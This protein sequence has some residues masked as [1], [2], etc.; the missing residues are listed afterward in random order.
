MS[1]ERYLSVYQQTD[2]VFIDIPGMNQ[3]LCQELVELFVC[4]RNQTNEFI[5]IDQEGKLTFATG[6]SGYFDGFENQTNVWDYFTEDVGQIIAD[7][8]ISG[9]II[10][11]FNTEGGWPPEFMKIVPG[12]AKFVK[13]TF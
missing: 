5:R 6:D 10:F 11:L 2:P 3:K 4:H 13:P 7:H 12:E 8:L 1:L 9:V